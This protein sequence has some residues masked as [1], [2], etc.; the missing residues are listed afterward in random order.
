[1]ENEE[2]KRYIPFKNYVLTILMLIAVILITIYFF[3][4][5][6]IKNEEKISQSYLVKNNLVTN[7]I[8]NVEEVRNILTENSTRL[9]L[10]ISY[11][12]SSK[13]YNIENDYKKIFD[14]YH[15]NDIFYLFDITDIKDNNKNYKNLINN[16]LDI[17]VN[18]FPVIVYYEDGQINSYKK[19]D[20]SKD[21]D[22]FLKKI[23]TE[24]NSL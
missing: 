10:Y 7:Q 16:L 5:Y 13:I 15:L 22:N 9:L 21:L 1:M 19:I 4:W 12:N 14:K 2:N 17:N 8:S 18:G 11:R 20:S 23:N 3:K 6:K 24:K